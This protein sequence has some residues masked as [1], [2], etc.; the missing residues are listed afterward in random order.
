MRPCQQSHWST[1]AIKSKKVT[2]T[3]SLSMSYRLTPVAWSP[4]TLLASKQ[5]QSLPIPFAHTNLHTHKTWICY[6]RYQIHD[7]WTVN[8]YQLIALHDKN[9]HKISTGITLTNKSQVNVCP[10]LSQTSYILKYSYLILQGKHN[11]TKLYYNNH[12][13]TYIRAKVGL[14]SQRASLS[15]HKL[16]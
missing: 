2:Y 7:A 16:N 12:F 9:S 1:I 11:F 8:I 6:L 10:I 14:C 5:M 3:T 15:W 4:N 13:N